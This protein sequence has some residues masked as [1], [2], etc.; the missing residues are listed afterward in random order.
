M[1]KRVLRIC[2]RTLV[3]GVEVVG[4]GVVRRA[5]LLEREAGA[6][7]VEKG[8]PA[9]AA[10]YGA[11]GGGRRRGGGGDTG[12]LTA[13]AGGVAP[14]P[15]RGAPAAAPHLDGLMALGS[16]V[17]ALARRLR[18]RA[19]TKDGEVAVAALMARSWKAAG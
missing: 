9:A 17:H 2:V 13:A 10:A 8:G 6:E 11:G 12:Q 16:A 18:S 1:E 14:P 19:V 3:G 5:L 15:G 7:G 4:H